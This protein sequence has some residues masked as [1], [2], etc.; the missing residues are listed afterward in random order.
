[1]AADHE[2]AVRQ[3]TP[4]DH[5]AVVAMTE[6][7]WSDRGGDYV[8]HVFP[9]MVAGDGPRQRTFVAEADGG[10]GDLVGLVQAVLLSDWEAWFQAMRVHPDHRGRGVSGALN[11]ACLEWARERGAAVGR[12]MVF[13]WNVEGLAASRANGFDPVTEFRWANPEPDAGATGADGAPGVREAPDDAHA[14]WT[15]SDAHRHLRGLGLD[16]EESWACSTVER[17][18]WHDAD[19]VLAVGEPVRAATYRSRTWERTDDDGESETVAE[20]GVGAWRDLDACRDLM[21][22]VAHDAADLDADRTRMLIP[23]TARH[24]SDVARAGWEVS[25]EPDFVLGRALADD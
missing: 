21:A 4:E 10:D 20:Y 23:E 9:D 14:F 7:T 2:L 22:V 11:D 3:A 19:R 17:D 12:L 1:M 5:D 13:S 8:A 25:D 18:R 15:T 6:D 24:V 16:T